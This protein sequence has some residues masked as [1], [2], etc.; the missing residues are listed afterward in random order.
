MISIVITIRGLVFSHVHFDSPFSLVFAVLFF[1]NRYRL[2]GMVFMATGLLESIK[3]L[4]LLPT[5]WK[6]VYGHNVESF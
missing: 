6:S 2:A 1:C 3:R 4:H 5:I